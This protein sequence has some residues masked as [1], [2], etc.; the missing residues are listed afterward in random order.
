MHT[1]K[2]DTC[3]G[4]SFAGARLGFRFSTSWNGAIDVATLMSRFTPRLPRLQYA[5]AI[6]HVIT[7]GDGRRQLFHDL[8]HYD[9]ITRGLKD[10]VGRFIS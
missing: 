2:C 3:K 6:Y 8:G 10:E 7:R 5:N 9:R 1:F 4:I